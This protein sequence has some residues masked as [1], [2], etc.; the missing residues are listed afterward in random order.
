MS[1][2]PATGSKY[3]RI[4]T[5]DDILELLGGINIWKKGG[6]WAPHKPLLLLMTLA[7]VQRGESRL[8]T[9]ESIEPMLKRLLQDYGP[10]RK[11]FHP[12]FPFWRLQ[13]DGDFW[14]VPQREKLIEARGDLKRTGDV[15]TRVLK[16]HGAEGGFSEE[17][18]AYL[19]KRPELVNKITQDILETHFT[20]SYYQELLDAVGMPWATVRKK[21]A[22]DPQ[23]RTSI[24]RIYSYRCA[25]CGY[26]GKLGGSALGIEAAHLKWHAAGGPDTANNGIALCSFH[27]KVLDRG[28][29]GLSDELTIDVSQDVHGGSQVEDLLLQYVGKELTPP[30]SGQEKPLLDY[31]EWHRSEVFKGP[32]RI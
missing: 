7:R 13:N 26:D 21:R 24:L 1:V 6:Q 32:G 17:V 23:F 11:S 12:E 18:D 29:M 31:V 28:A 16:E 30:Q 3:K 20:E 8:A 2:E 25:V 10:R 9:F 22:R 14:V 27:H 4:M 5:D 19:R 15:P